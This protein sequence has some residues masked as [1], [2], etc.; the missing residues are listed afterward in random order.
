MTLT[1]GES[2]PLLKV[3]G[4]SSEFC[5]WLHTTLQMAATFGHIPQC[6]FMQLIDINPIFLIEPVGL[7]LW[8][9]PALLL[10]SF[11]NCEPCSSWSQQMLALLRVIPLVFQIFFS[12]SD[13]WDSSMRLKFLFFF[14]F[15]KNASIGKHVHNR[16]YSFITS[17]IPKHTSQEVASVSGIEGTHSQPRERANMRL[18]S[19]WPK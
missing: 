10:H 12:Y 7:M 15:C 9:R 17:C 19:T 11:C 1:A 4:L 3:E 18:P 13:N 16:Y 6:I 8:S 5:T 2:C 14:Y